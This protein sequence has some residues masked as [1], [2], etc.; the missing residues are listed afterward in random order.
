[1]DVIFTNPPYN[2]KHEVLQ[3][4]FESGK[5][6]CLLVPYQQ[7]TTNKFKNMRHTSH[8]L[9]IGVLSNS[10]KFTKADGTIVQIGELIWLFG[11][12]KSFTCANSIEFL[13]A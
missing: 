10:H 6:F 9:H 12:F 1:V 3:K 11:N 7:L 5:P 13:Y 2:Q 4:C 8:Y